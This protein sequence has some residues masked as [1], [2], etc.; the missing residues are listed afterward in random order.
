MK[1][2]TCHTCFNYGY[3]QCPYYPEEPSVEVCDNHRDER[4]I[5]NQ[6][7]LDLSKACLKLIDKNT[8]GF[9]YE[10]WDRRRRDQEFAKQVFLGYHIVD[11]DVWENPHIYGEHGYV[12]NEEA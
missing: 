9:V 6:K 2:N 12:Y 3:P 4:M 1:E 7:T 11:K 5:F 8:D 10:T